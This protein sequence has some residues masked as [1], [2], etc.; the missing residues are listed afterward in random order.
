MIRIKL[1]AA[2][3]AALLVITGLPVCA[4]NGGGTG[5]IFLTLGDD[6]ANGSGLSSPL[7]TRYGV[8]AAAKLGM[9]GIS[10]AVDGM[11]VGGMISAIRSGAYTESLLKADA[12][13]LCIG[14]N[15]LYVALESKANSA[16][17]KY[18]ITYEEF[19]KKLSDGSLAQEDSAAVSALSA[20]LSAK[21][22]F[23]ES[24]E[25]FTVG[26]ETVL[27][28]INEL[29]PDVTVYLS[30]LFNPYS[31][32]DAVTVGGAVVD[33][34]TIGASITDKFNDAAASSH[35]YVR[36]IDSGAR[37][38]PA[39]LKRSDGG[40]PVY[41]WPNEAGHTA[42]S[43]LLANSAKI[44][45]TADISGHLG[46]KYIR[47]ILRTGAFDGF[48]ENDSFKPD[49]YMTRGMFVTAVCRILGGN[50]DKY[51]D[52]PMFIDAPI[53]DKYTRYVNWA[54]LNGIASGVSDLYFEPYSNITREQMAQ[55][56]SNVIEQMAMKPEYTGEVTASF[57]DASSV[58]DWAYDAV[59]M[60][61]RLGLYKG[62]ADGKLNPQSP[63]TNAEVA[64]ILY[65]LD[66]LCPMYGYLT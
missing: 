62:D 34:R 59:E 35:G 50:A 8:T 33:L 66:E 51:K 29:A 14:Q 65:R 5:Y 55:M 43:N 54:K 30:T 42:V 22:A 44:G 63:I 47:G 52:R 28:L 56:I 6:F 31:G 61:R 17:A 20:A 40:T 18:G 2:F 38:T 41:P 60:M 24:I 15:D 19:Y 37:I 7:S 45:G 36:V 48:L 21:D 11:T 64:T 9:E 53:T 27:T 58:S 4:M 39:M 12:L 25:S 57:T 32:I 23:S 1:I 49:E 46:E 3:L 10:F 13:S 16:L 26:L